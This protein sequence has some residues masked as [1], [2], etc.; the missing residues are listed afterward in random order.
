[1]PTSDETLKS[2]G[3]DCGGYVCKFH[4]LEPTVQ[5]HIAQLEAELAE[6]KDRRPTYGSVV[7][8]L[9][10]EENENQRLRDVDAMAQ[11]IRIVDLISSNAEAII[12]ALKEG[13]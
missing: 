13:G 5:E 2:C 3:K 10:V 9:T 7:Q 12:D 4:S 11:A 1:M 6:Y 8:A